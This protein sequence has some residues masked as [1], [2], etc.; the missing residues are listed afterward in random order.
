MLKVSNVNDIYHAVLNHP[1]FRCDR[2][3]RPASRSNDCGG[4]GSAFFWITMRSFVLVLTHYLHIISSI[5]RGIP[6][7]TDSFS[8]AC[9]GGIMDRMKSETDKQIPEEFMR[10]SKIVQVTLIFIIVIH[11]TWLAINYCN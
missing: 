10:S 8:A 5:I 6:S 4:E 3:H 11:H 1:P 9:V 2:S 7:K